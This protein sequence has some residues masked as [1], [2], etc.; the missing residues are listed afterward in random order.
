MA[1][2]TGLD[3][4]FCPVGK[5]YGSHQCL[6]WRQELPTGQFHCYGFE[7]RVGTKQ[8]P[9]RINGWEFVA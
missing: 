4:H 9:S 3:L 1:E 5:K 8:I 6:H 2:A 7:S